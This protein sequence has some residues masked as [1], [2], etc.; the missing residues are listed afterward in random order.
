MDIEGVPIEAPFAASFP[1][2][3]RV[4]VLAG[5]GILCWATNLHGLHILGIDAAAA[6][7]IRPFDANSLAPLRLTRRRFKTPFATLALV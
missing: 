5:T 1:L 2:P 3:F 6:L 7:D 4:L